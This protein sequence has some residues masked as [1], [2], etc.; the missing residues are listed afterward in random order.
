MR[1]KVARADVAYACSGHRGHCSLDLR[2]SRVASGGTS[3]AK[4]NAF[5][6][7][8][9]TS[10]GNSA[11]VLHDFTRTCRIERRT[12]CG[13]YRPRLAKIRG[14]IEVRRHQHENTFG[15]I[16]SGRQRQCFVDVRVHEGTAALCP[17]FAFAIS[18]TTA[19][20]GRPAAKRFRATS[21][22]TLPVIPVIAN[23][24]LLSPNR[25]NVLPQ[26]FARE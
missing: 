14:R 26:P 21:P 17:G 8:E 1:R 11:S 13:S 3:T 20:T 19:R 24:G 16:E 7:V 5:M 9:L 10:T 18:R 23:I 12:Q 4:T 25:F 6:F 15:S 2:D 22:P